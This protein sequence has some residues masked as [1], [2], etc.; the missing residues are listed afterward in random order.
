[1]PAV[2]LGRLD[3]DV[4]GFGNL[5]VTVPLDK[6]LDNLLLSLRET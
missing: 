5:F 4:E 2:S 3:A 6:E 1:V